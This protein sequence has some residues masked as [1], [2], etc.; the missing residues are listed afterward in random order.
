MQRVYRNAP[1]NQIKP[2]PHNARTHSSKQIKQIA[3]SIAKLGFGAPVILDENGVLLAGEGRWRAAKLIQRVPGD[4]ALRV[5]S[6][7]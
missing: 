6:F 7:T 4:A 1:T 5:R 2:N 3:D